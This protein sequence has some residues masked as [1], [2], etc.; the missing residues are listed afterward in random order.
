MVVLNVLRVVHCVDE[1][2]SEFLK[3]TM[4][5][6]RSDLAGQYRQISK[7][8]LDAGALPSDA[9][10]FRIESW[11]VGLVVSS[12]LK[13]AMESVG[14]VGAKFKELRVSAPRAEN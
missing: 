7:L 12:D 10:F 3:W 5:D 1:A 14:C 11:L 9:H 13:D 2:R 8:V 6:H 4:N